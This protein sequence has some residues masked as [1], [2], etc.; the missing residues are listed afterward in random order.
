MKID[1]SLF[2]A[3]QRIA[4]LGFD[5][6]I[7]GSGAAAFVYSTANDRAIEIS[8]DHTGYYI[9]LFEAPHDNS[10]RDYLQDDIEHSIEQ[11]IAW[12]QRRETD[13]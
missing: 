7:R 3:R 11:A 4:D 6:T 10:V 12:L 9:E 13:F 2:L 1:D 5:T 8:R